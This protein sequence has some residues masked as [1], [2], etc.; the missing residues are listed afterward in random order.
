MALAFVM[1]ILSAASPAVI[2]G[3]SLSLDTPYPAVEA[4]AGG[5]VSLTLNVRTDAARRVDLAV[6]SVP[7]GWG[8]SL[9]GG[10]FLIGSVTADPKA[11]PDIKLEVKIPDDA[12][13]GTYRIVVRA[14]SSGLSSS[15]PVDIRIAEATGGGL[16]FT[17]PIA[18]T[19]PFCERSSSLCWPTARTGS[20]AGSPS[21]T[22]TFNL[23]LNN[24]S[25]ADVTYTLNATG[26]D[27][28]QVSAKPA[29]QSQAASATVT[30]GSTSA[31]TVTAT[32]PSSAAAGS[33]PIAVQAMANGQPVNQALAVEITGEFKLDLSTPDQRLS[34]HGVAGSA[35][36]QQFVV[37][38][39]G[40][41]PLT[42]VKL[43]ATPPTNWKV[44]F[45]QP[46]VDI[47]ANDKA[48]VTATIVP[49][50]DAVA[51]DY[52]ISV[53]ATAEQAN[54]S[55]DLRFTVETST[56]WA[57]IGIGLIV[58]TLGALGW[59]FRRFGRR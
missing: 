1:T 9:H 38:N 24:D 49:S 34:T 29:S 19:R 17:T 20:T 56:T 45:D 41:A 40:S 31:V 4:A 22:F 53:T 51:G 55:Q 8:A 33:Y 21:T 43:T 13:T 16:S 47:A 59:V 10:G 14:T 44:T 50:G 15:L 35:T 7:K 23:T 42:G 48:T 2:L 25:P 11:P 30:A 28:W 27:G 26:P 54:Q 12:A 3:A 46:S 58:I 37:Q 6:T 32:P 18:S 52:V 39:T 36:Q 57:I 5:K